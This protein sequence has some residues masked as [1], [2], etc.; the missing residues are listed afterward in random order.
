MACKHDLHLSQG[1]TADDNSCTQLPCRYLALVLVNALLAH[2]STMFSLGVHS[3]S[4]RATFESGLPLREEAARALR[5]YPISL[6][7][8]SIPIRKYDTELVFPF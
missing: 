5:N 2:S 3:C 4:S 1:C 7:V 8:D 6:R